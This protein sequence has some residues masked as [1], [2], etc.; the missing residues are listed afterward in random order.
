M[1]LG[2]PT[3]NYRHRTYT[4]QESNDPS[5]TQTDNENDTESQPEINP[6]SR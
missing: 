5:E 4:I 2:E 3:R 1:Y 6:K